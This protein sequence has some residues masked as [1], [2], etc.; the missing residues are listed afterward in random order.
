MEDTKPTI[1][2]EPTPARHNGNRYRGKKKSGKTSSSASGFKGH[3]PELAG[4]VYTYDAG[5]R[6]DQYDKTTE[7]IAEYMKRHYVI[8]NGEILENCCSGS[9]RAMIGAQ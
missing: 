6:A 4:Y 8:K 5:T 3:C 7:F 9:L 1:K 2:T